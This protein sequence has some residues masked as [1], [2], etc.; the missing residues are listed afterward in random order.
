MPS[1][2]KE[3]NRFRKRNIQDDIDKEY[4]RSFEH[5]YENLFFEKYAF[6]FER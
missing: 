3:W 2:G 6:I 1:Y 4:L 5:A